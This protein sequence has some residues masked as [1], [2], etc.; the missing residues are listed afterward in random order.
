MQVTGEHVANSYLA[1][2]E[3]TPV[4]ISQAES[5]NAFW[6]EEINAGMPPPDKLWCSPFTRAARTCQITFGDILIESGK[7][8][9]FVLEV[10]RSLRCLRA[11]VDF[12]FSVSK[13]NNWC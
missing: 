1:D 6:K 12:Q 13:G 9:P 11:R 7:C 5:A 2:A 8:R 10:F 4:G 3:L